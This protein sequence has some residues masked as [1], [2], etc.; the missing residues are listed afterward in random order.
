M[1]GSVSYVTVG[2]V[3]YPRISVYWKDIIGDA[4]SADVRMSKQLLCPVI[5]TEGYLFDHFVEDGEKY[6]RTFA[7]WSYYEPEDESSFGDRNCFPVSVLT[8]ESRKE[9]KVITAWV[10]AN[11]EQ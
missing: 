11:E 7:T 8:K 2:G 5:C 9:L 10:E 6:I 3:K 1:D 4:S